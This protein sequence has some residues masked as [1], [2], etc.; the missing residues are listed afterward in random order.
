MSAIHDTMRAA[1]YGV[2]IETTGLSKQQL[3]QAI[4]TVVGGTTIQTE[5]GAWVALASDGRKWTVVNDASIHH[6]GNGTGEVVSPVLTY[7][8]LDTL[9][10]I[11][12]ALRGAGA[13]VDESCGLHIHV[14][15]TSLQPASVARLLKIVAKQ[16]RYIEKALKIQSARLGHYTK[17]TNP[18]V[19][20]RMNGIESREQLHR[21]WYGN[22]SYC[23]GRYDCTRYHGVN[24]NSWFFRGTVEFRWFEGTMHAGEVKAY[25]HL[26]L[27]LVAKAIIAKAAGGTARAYSEASAKYDFRVVLLGLGLIGEEFKNTRSHLLKNLPGDAAWKSPRPA[28]AATPAA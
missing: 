12:R 17:P 11:V 16:E 9:Q 24:V 19:V 4:Q 7:A 26:C 28:T 2:E 3:A 14:S 15:H 6:T 20:A 18:T 21:A 22:A 1:K 5:T 23:G 8:D 27:A 13:K 25:I 10:A